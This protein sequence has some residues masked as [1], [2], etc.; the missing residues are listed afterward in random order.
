M[1]TGKRFRIGGLS[2]ALLAAAALAVG[3]SARSG[4]GVGGGTARSVATSP[5][6]AAAGSARTA[7]SSQTALEF[8]GTIDYLVGRVTVNGAAAT[9]GQAVAAN[10]V[11]RTG[12]G[13]MAEVTFNGANI[14]QIEANSEVALD[15]RTL[16]LSNGSVALV[17]K[18]LARVA[19]G[20]RFDVVTPTAVA[21]VRGTAFFVK[22]ESPDETY[23]CL[24]NG[25]L[26]LENPAGVLLKE[27]EAAHHKAERFVRTGGRI[28]LQPAPL[29]YHTDAQM[30]SLAKKIGTSI[31]WKVI[32]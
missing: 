25:R 26:W 9:L 20:D 30:E 7:G 18:H 24:C 27:I 3:C 13:S 1:T 12:S 23:V 31:D 15:A 16:R 17:L 6:D 28:L 22:V 29:L 4:G 5:T 21:G 32:Q 11:L 8:K 2:I 19:A 14:V 10:D